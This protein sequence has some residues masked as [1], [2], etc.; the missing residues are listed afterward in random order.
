MT[1][2]NTQARLHEHAGRVALLLSD[3]KGRYPCETLYLSTDLARKLANALAF[4]AD[5][6]GQGY[7][8]PTTGINREA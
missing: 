1:Q 8:F 5:Q 6:I 4:A 2:T 3:D 7:H